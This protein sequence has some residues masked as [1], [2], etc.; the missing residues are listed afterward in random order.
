MVAVVDTTLI[1]VRRHAAWTFGFSV[2]VIGSVEGWNVG[3]GR[4]LGSDLVLIDFEFW[5]H[6]YPLSRS[7]RESCSMFGFW[8]HVEWEECVLGLT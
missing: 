2:T 4:A 8:D 1:H 7:R 6:P 3:F 5:V